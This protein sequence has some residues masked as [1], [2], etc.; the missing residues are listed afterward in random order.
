MLETPTHDA[1]TAKIKRLA[2]YAMCHYTPEKSIHQ[3]LLVVHP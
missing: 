3:I 2:I 1:T